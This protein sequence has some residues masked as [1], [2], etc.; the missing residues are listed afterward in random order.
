MVRPKT[1]D[2]MNTPFQYGDREGRTRIALAI[3][4]TN[5][6]PSCNA[7]KASQTGNAGTFVVV[8]RISLPSPIVPSPRHHTPPTNQPDDG[9]GGEAT[10]SASDHSCHAFRFSISIGLRLKLTGTGFNGRVVS[11]AIAEIS[12][13]T[14]DPQ[15]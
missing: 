4:D 9:K 7:L 12:D 1:P 11:R 3:L 15:T 5:N 10:F 14:H 13:S 8:P 6:D 2:H